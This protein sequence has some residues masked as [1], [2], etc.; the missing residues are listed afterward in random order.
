MFC[1]IEHLNLLKNGSCTVVLH[2]VSDSWF[3]FDLFRFQRRANRM[4]A[5]EEI[6]FASWFVYS[7]VLLQLS[8]TQ[9]LHLFEALD[10]THQ[11]SFLFYTNL[12][13][14]LEPKDCL[15]AWGG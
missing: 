11:H 13:A 3:F 5:L 8:L 12:K 7:V 1:L 14:S 4:P 15:H 10:P 2:H 6:A 9:E